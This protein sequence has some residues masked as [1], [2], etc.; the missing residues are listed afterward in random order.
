[1]KIDG[2]GQEETKGRGHREKER[3]SESEREREMA[4]ANGWGTG[5]G[6]L[7]RGP[8]LSICVI[9]VCM[10]SDRKYGCLFSIPAHLF[11][12][13]L[14]SPPSVSFYLSRA[15]FASS[16]IPFFLSFLPSSSF[17]SLPFR[18]STPSLILV[19]DGQTFATHVTTL[20]N[21]K[22]QESSLQGC[23]FRIRIRR[24][25][26]VHL[27]AS[28]DPDCFHCPLARHPRLYYHPALVPATAPVLPGQRAW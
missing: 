4:A 3:K 6:G 27:G 25:G 13:F 8:R 9:R 14:L 7:G 2:A 26:S 5:A 28:S 21:S 18:S 12:F 1:M 17:L 15:S 19:P 16:F 11:F 22:V 10:L 20:R 23:H 24:V